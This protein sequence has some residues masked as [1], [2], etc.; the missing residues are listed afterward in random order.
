MGILATVD[1]LSA[2]TRVRCLPDGEAQK[3][4]GLYRG[5]S[6]D[7]RRR[8]HRRIEVRHSSASLWIGRV[9]RSLLSSRRETQHRGQDA[10]R[11]ALHGR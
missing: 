11:Q 9:R 2:G 8:V 10:C 4:D 6:R 1:F 5:K 3:C 7:P